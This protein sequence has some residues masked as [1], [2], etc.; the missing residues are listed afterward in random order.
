VPQLAI[1]RLAGLAS[2][3]VDVDHVDW[4]RSD[5][6]HR[7]RMRNQGLTRPD[8]LD[9]PHGRCVIVD[10]TDDAALVGDEALLVASLPAARR[11]ELLTGRAA[12]RTLL[13]EDVA[14]ARDDRGAPVLPAGWVG[15]ISHKHERAAALIAPADA[16]F[17]GVDLETAAP[18]RQA[19][20]R[21]I[22]T[23]REQQALREPREVTLR[24]AIKEAIYKAV[25]P[26]VR[27]YVGFTEVE[28]ELDT[29]GNV[30]VHVLDTARLPVVVEAWWQ[31]RDGLWLATARA[32]RR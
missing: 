19:I 17:V 2:H 30:A 6:L 10:V 16:G 22:L 11:R 18:A 7:S 31:E 28:L 3:L 9:T 32:T 21:R 13:G 12:L 24:F 5:K 15:S 20:E 23:P 8:V 29:D 25:D 4:Q 26:I 14:I 27:R 1:K